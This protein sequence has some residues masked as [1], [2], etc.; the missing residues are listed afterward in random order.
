MALQ[1]GGAASPL[2]PRHPPSP[3]LP[4]SPGQSLQDALNFGCR[5]AG[6]K[7]GIQGYD[8]IV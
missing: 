3:H 4:P 2:A 5:I 6:K 8:G 1:S 7:C